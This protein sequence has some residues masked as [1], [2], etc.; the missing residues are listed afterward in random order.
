MQKVISNIASLDPYLQHGYVGVQKND[1]FFSVAD[2]ILYDA[3]KP[4]KKRQKLGSLQ[5]ADRGRDRRL[6]FT[7]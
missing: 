1:K 7:A 3:A 2:G 4:A 5:F 6:S